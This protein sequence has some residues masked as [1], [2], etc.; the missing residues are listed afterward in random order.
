M[1]KE[2]RNLFGYAKPVGVDTGSANS[3]L[4]L[5]TLFVILAHV[6]LSRSRNRPRT[7]KAPPA[8]CARVVETI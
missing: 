2:H 3:D 4:V 5:H 1:L 8:F 6:E 7:G